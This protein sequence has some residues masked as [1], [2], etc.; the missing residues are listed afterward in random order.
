MLSLMG[1][2][3]NIFAVGVGRYTKTSLEQRVSFTAAKSIWN[4]AASR[5]LAA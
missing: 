4:E 1:K 5:L 3:R 2:V